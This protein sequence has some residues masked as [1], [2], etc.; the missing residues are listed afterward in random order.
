MI[1]SYI[2]VGS[3]IGDRIGYVQQAHCLLNDTEG[4]QVLEGSSFYETEPVGYKNQEWFINAVL[5]ITTTLSAEELLS[6][7]LRIEKQL[8][9]V[10]HPELPKNGPRVL[11]LD[12][13]FYDNKV[14]NSD[15]MEI[16]H[17]RMH[18]RA[19]AL[20]PLLE[21]DADLVHPVFNKTISELHEN[22]DEPEE[23]YLYGT[24]EIDF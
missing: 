16:P 13:L 6:Q 17:P 8:G 21:L 23:V 9:R 12:I 7:C 24:R 1:I 15:I 2:G 4:V 18:K 11:D 14:I 10:R 3:N 22:L 19:Y 20:V 5:K